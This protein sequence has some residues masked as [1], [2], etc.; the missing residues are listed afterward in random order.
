MTEIESIVC[1]FTRYV[2][3][4]FKTKHVDYS[5]LWYP[6]LSKNEHGIKSLDVELVNS[7]QK[8]FIKKKPNLLLSFFIKEISYPCDMM[9]PSHFKITISKHDES[10][11]VYKLPISELMEVYNSARLKAK[12]YQNELSLIKEQQEI[13]NLSILI[14]NS[15]N[16]KATIQ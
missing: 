6:N 9:L 11:H 10:K 3:N 4:N 14:N 13:S 12:E 2:L 5:S 16:M 1:Q 15:I 7:I 8:T